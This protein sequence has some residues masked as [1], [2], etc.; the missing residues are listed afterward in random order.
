M[1]GWGLDVGVDR[2]GS[3]KMMFGTSQANAVVAG[4]VP[5]LRSVAVAAG[6][7]LET[8]ALVTARV[9][10]LVLKDVLKD[11]GDSPNLYVNNGLVNPK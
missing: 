8:L 6:A 11:L 9:K 7:P 10:E 5:Y 3:W 1:G 2:P 4:L